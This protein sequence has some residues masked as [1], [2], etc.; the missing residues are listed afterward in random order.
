MFRALSAH[1]QEDTVVYMQH[2]VLSISTRVRGDLSVHS[3]NEFSLKLCTDRL[4]RTPVES[5]STICCMYTTV[6]F[7]R[8][9]LE[10]RKM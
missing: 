10:A 4:P 2:M 6:S 1:L 3:L 9:A 8:R 5:D 7:W